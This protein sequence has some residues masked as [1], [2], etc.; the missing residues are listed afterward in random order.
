MATPVLI[1]GIAAGLDMINQMKGVEAIV[2]NDED[3]IY[4]SNNIRLNQYT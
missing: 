2:V 1:M 3:E 4:V